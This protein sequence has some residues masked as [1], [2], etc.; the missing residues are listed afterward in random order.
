MRKRD[1]PLFAS[2]RLHSDVGA[3]TKAEPPSTFFEKGHV[4]GM[5]WPAL[6][7][8]Y[9]KHYLHRQ[10]ARAATLPLLNWQEVFGEAGTDVPAVGGPAVRSATGRTFFGNNRDANDVNVVHYA[11][12]SLNLGTVSLSPA[13]GDFLPRSIARSGDVIAV[14]GRNDTVALAGV[15]LLTE[16]A[17]NATPS[18]A[19]VTGVI[20]TADSP[21]FVV[22]DETSGYIYAVDQGSED[23]AMA[24]FDGSTWGTDAFE[25]D[26]RP[27][28]GVNGLTGGVGGL[29]VRDGVVSIASRVE[30]AVV[31]LHK[32]FGEASAATAQTEVDGTILDFRYLEEEQLYRCIVADTSSVHVL[33]FA[34]PDGEITVHEDGFSFA[35]ASAVALDWVIVVFNSASATLHW[36]YEP[37]GDEHVL[38][39]MPSPVAL[40]T[41]FTDGARLFL[42]MIGEIAGTDYV[43]LLS[44]FVAT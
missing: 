8:N 19:E 20:G 17:A 31:F 13:S 3:P 30:G 36:R 5:G 37:R 1:V 2:N 24:R 43:R 15:F 32:P 27:T 4:P 21:T 41:V 28:V 10:V 39:M 7:E 22:T 35:S 14:G 12:P 6:W 38:S 18:V 23:G 16:Q 33:E 44:S 25:H 11:G 9:V 29:V 26:L 40:G 42:S 34:E